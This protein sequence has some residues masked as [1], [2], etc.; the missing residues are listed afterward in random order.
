MIETM[1]Q[2]IRRAVLTPAVLLLV[3]AC[4][5]GGGAASGPT[6]E[7]PSAAQPPF[8]AGSTAPPAPGRVTAPPVTPPDRSAPPALGPV[9]QLKLPAIQEFTLGNG[10]RVLVM[11]KHDLPI[12]QVNIMLNAGSINEPAGKTSL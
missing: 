6:V 10:M 7:P 2:P 4:A 1:K 9:P 3:T 8:V 11:E 12:A 5:S